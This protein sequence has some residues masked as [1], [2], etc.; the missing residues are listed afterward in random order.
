MIVLGIDPGTDKSG[1]VLYGT[2]PKIVYL[3]GE[4]GN[5]ELLTWLRNGTGFGTPQDICNVPTF[6]AIETV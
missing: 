6:I 1:F 4:M 2:D 5:P 3:A